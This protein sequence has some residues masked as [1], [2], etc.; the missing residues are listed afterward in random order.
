MRG[1]LRKN[2]PNIIKIVLDKAEKRRILPVQ[3]KNSA[4]IAG[5]MKSLKGG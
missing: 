2:Y 1:I 4:S 5:I 3:Y